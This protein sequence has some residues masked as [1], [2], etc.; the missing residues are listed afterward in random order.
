MTRERYIRDDLHCFYNENQGIR[1]KKH[2]K[3]ESVTC[4]SVITRFYC[5]SEC[6]HGGEEMWCLSRMTISPNLIGQK[7][8]HNHPYSLFRVFMLSLIHI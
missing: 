4:M 7:E 5:S 2:Y 1:E 6:G 3:G 8:A